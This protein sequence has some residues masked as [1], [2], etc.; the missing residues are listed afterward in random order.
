M[1]VLKKNFFILTASSIIF[2]MFTLIALASGPIV[3]SNVQVRQQ[4]D[5]IIVNY[6]LSHPGDGE[7]FIELEFAA[8]GTDFS[9]VSEHNER[10]EG[11]IAIVA[12]GQGKEVRWQAAVALAGQYSNKAKVRI[13]ADY[14]FIGVPGHPGVILD[15]TTGFMWTQSVNLAVGEKGMTDIGDRSYNSTIK[16][17]EAMNNGSKTN[18]GYTDWQLPSKDDFSTLRY[19]DQFP[20]GHPF[21]YYNSGEPLKYYNYNEKCMCNCSYNQYFWSSYVN[22]NNFYFSISPLDKSYSYSYSY[23][24]S[25]SSSSPSSS[26][27][28]YYYVTLNGSQIGDKYCAHCG[29]FIW[30]IRKP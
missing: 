10:I 23:S 17:V 18:F 9:R 4:G 12:P 8:N 13:K 19:N 11:D 3:V 6:D 24:F 28:Y 21:T 16:W 7:I 14:R 15:K 27:S 2:Y 25:S 22:S 5:W 26:S 1:N 29:P 30:L 20:S